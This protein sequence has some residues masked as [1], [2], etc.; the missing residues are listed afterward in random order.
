MNLEDGHLE[1]L[2]NDVCCASIQNVIVVATKT[3]TQNLVCTSAIRLYKL[4]EARS[5][6]AD[7]LRSVRQQLKLHG[8]LARRS[9]HAFGVMLM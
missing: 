8:K 4:T 5:G 7:V 9:N 6:F 3:M 2:S 1:T